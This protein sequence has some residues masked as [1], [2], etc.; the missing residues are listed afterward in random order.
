MLLAQREMRSD[1]K[2]HEIL[3]GESAE[4]LANAEVAFL[5]LSLS[6]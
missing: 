5:G 2:S 3:Q 4:Q 6:I 1:M